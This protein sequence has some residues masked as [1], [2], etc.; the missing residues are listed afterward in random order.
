M[1]RRGGR[2]FVVLSGAERAMEAFKEEI[3]E[4]LGLGD[5]VRSSG[6][7]GLTTQEV[8][9]IGGEMVKRIMVA[10]EIAVLE[11]FKAGQKLSPTIPDHTIIN[12]ADPYRKIAETRGETAAM[13]KYVNQS[14]TPPNQM[15]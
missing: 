4:D 14:S 9:S 11:R 6:W 3:A 8:G 13:A 1:P 10:G 15:Q 2:H 5:K 12:N 7:T